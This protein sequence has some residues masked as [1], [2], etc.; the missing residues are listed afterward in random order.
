[1]TKQ[2]TT[3]DG[4]EVEIL[5]TTV[6]NK[7][8]PVAALVR[9]AK[10]EQEVKRYTSEGKYYADVSMSVYDLIEVNKVKEETPVNKLIEL[11]KIYQTREG[12]PIEILTISAKNTSYPVIALITHEDGQQETIRF[13]AEGFYNKAGT[14][15]NDLVEVNPYA[16][17]K[18]GDKVLVSDNGVDWEKRY[19]SHVTDDGKPSTFYGGSISRSNIAQT[20]G[21]NFCKKVTD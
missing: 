6:C 2:Y 17:F 16:D 9:N 19:F 1:M 14:S 7:E 11:G 15:E 10:D 4:R 18:V 12:K 5:S 21:W 20:I 13:T 3:T 8:Y